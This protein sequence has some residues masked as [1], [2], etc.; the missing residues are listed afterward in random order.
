M[1]VWFLSSIFPQPYDPTRGIFCAHLCKAL[2]RKHAVQVI[3]PRSWL[4]AWRYRHQL[5]RLSPGQDETWQELPV[6]RPIYYYPPKVCRAT[7]GWWMEWSARATIRSLLAQTPPDC[8]VS[9]WAHPDGA[10]AVRAG[11]LAGVPT[12]IIVGGSDVLLLSREP[13]RR[14]CVQNALQAADAVVAVSEDLK[15]RVVELG[16]NAARAHVVRQGLD[17][18]LFYPA[19]RQL[20]RSSL[21][22]APTEPILIWVGRMAPVKGLDVLLAACARLKDR[23]QAFHL[24]LIGDGPLRPSLASL[25]EKLGLGQRV[26][27]VGTKS[28]AELPDWYRAADF[29]VLP[30]WSEGLPNVLRESVACGTPFIASRVGG[31]PEIADD[32]RDRLVP[33]GDPEG[34]A[35]T[36]QAAISKRGDSLPA[37]VRF[38]GWEEHAETILALLCSKGSPANVSCHRDIQGR[39]P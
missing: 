35:E 16:V 2:A 20:A 25:A 14:R 22:I 30:S 1:R 19:D 11:K 21:G 6:R 27:F 24:Y 5:A 26:S 4:E 38:A 37:P 34:W 28:P 23:E 12:G 18:E 3:A 13:W 9:Y 39:L 10:V 33:P 36:I 7:Y 29:T 32:R 8:I 31:I 17:E 15:S